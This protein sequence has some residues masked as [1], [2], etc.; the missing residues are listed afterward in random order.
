MEKIKYSV[1]QI[2]QKVS[3]KAEFES[4]LFNIFLKDISEHIDIKGT[5][6]PA[7]NKLR[8]PRLLFAK[9]LAIASFTS[10]RLQKKIEL[11]NQYCKNWNLESN[12]NKYETTVFKKGG[13]LKATER[14]RMNGQSMKVVDKL[15]YLGVAL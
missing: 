9:D 13:K 10:Y 14:W 1:E 15:N 11:V 8:I 3:I 2:K 5:N 7:I 4:I 6:N 12:M